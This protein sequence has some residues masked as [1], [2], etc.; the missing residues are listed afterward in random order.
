M[1]EEQSFPEQVYEDMGDMWDWLGIGDVTAVKVVLVCLAI[2]AIAFLLRGVLRGVF[3][4]SLGSYSPPAR[5]PF[6][7]AED[8][9]ASR[10]RKRMRT[11]FEQVDP[12]IYDFHGPDPTPNL[13]SLTKTP[14]LSQLKDNIDLGRLR[15]PPQP[16]WKMAED[17]FV[18]KNMTNLHSRRKKRDD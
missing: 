7:D 4:G 18:P 9:W 5:R 3:F 13:T 12:R 1:P 6:Q 17:L 16:D 8:E 10:P 2:L 11:G 14:D 15:N